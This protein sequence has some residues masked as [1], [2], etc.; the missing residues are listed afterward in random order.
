[1]C[2]KINTAE[3]HNFLFATTRQGTAGLVCQKRPSSDRE[4]VEAMSADSKESG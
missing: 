4:T 1:M 3:T 2:I